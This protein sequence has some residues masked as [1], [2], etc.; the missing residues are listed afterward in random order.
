MTKEMTSSFEQKNVIQL[1][2]AEQIV[3]IRRTLPVGDNALKGHRASWVIYWNLKI[4]PR[5]MSGDDN[6]LNPSD[7]A[8]TALQSTMAG[9]LV[10]W[11]PHFVLEISQK[12]SF[13]AQR[14]LG[15]PEVPSRFCWRLVDWQGGQQLFVELQTQNTDMQIV[16]ERR[17]ALQNWTWMSERFSR[18][19]SG[20][21]GAGH[22]LVSRHVVL[23]GPTRSC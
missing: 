16:G 3:F 17:L 4:I 21:G 23:R 6:P 9:W 10:L 19:V 7:S 1:K 22:S 20:K 14:F 5:E 13:G 18:A 2:N 15:N 8:S 12:K 11:R